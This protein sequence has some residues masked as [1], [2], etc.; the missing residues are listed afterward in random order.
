M[1]LAIFSQESSKNLVSNLSL[2]FK[3]NPNRNCLQMQMEYLWA[4]FKQALTI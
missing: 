2:D 4:Q 3:R 1:I